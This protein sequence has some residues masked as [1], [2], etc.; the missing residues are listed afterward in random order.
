MSAVKKP[1]DRG[2]SHKRDILPLPLPPAPQYL[3]TWSWRDPQ[4]GETI[5]QWRDRADRLRA[6]L[7]G[8]AANWCAPGQRVRIVHDPRTFE[9][10]IEERIGTIIKRCGEPFTDYARVAIDLIGRETKVR[11]HLLPLETIEPF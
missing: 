1:L 2:Q 3:G 6:E 4:P 10:W 11:L 9:P 8:R 5:R 7:E